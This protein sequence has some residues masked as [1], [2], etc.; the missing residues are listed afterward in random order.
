MG[1]AKRKIRA[2]AEKRLEIILKREANHA[3]GREMQRRTMT[4]NAQSLYDRY[5][6]LTM[7]SPHLTGELR[8]SVQ[9]H[10]AQLKKMLMDAGTFRD[11][12]MG[13]SAY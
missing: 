2:V 11:P 8:G 4:A 5:T 13:V 10:K 12:R 1:A 7:T 3:I 6:H 9:A